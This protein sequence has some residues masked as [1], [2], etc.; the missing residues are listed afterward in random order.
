[1]CVPLP[2]V[3][4]LALDQHDGVLLP[5]LIDETGCEQTER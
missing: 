5:L 4:M 2:V 3:R 1:M